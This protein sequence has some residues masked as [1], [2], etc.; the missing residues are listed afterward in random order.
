V[1]VSLVAPG[2]RG[3]ARVELK[4]LNSIR[5]AGDAVA[6]E[7]ARQAKLLAALAR[8]RGPGPTHETRGWHA[9]SSR[10]FAMRGKEHATD[11]RYLPEPDLPAL[12]L[13][14]DDL[15]RLEAE[16][17]PSAS[18]IRSRW[19][20]SLG[21]TRAHATALTRTPGRAA[22]FE[23]CLAAGAEPTAAAKWI[24]NELAAAS[25]PRPTVRCED[26]LAPRALAELLDLVE[27]GR[28]TRAGQAR[29]FAAH[30]AQLDGTSR[31]HPTQLA[32]ELGLLDP[33]TTRMRGFDN[34][35]AALVRDALAARPEAVS[36]V[37]AGKAK[38][39]DALVGAVMG[40][41]DGRAEG[42]A[43]RRAL[44][45]ALASEPA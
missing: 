7:F 4:N 43:V 6:H 42:Q 28:L 3:F 24:T 45:L 15:E 16:R 44:L 2:Q 13:T 40:R 33:F 10:S 1:N 9:P 23:A 19:Q 26:L 5:A 12:S 20:Q 37:R 30:L 38:A 32:A 22:Y 18:N 34:D 8:G 29:V 31:R 27:R 36:D 21:L 17:P 35:L 11:Y 14:A 41:A 25:R 39:L